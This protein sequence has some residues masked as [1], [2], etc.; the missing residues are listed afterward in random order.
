MLRETAA[1]LIAAVCIFSILKLH[2][3]HEVMNSQ[4][5]KDVVQFDQIGKIL[6]TSNKK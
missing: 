1:F 2:H 3:R 4:H 6:L 5:F